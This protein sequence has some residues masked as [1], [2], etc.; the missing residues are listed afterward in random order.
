MCSVC[1]HLLQCGCNTAVYS[2]I[3]CSMLQGHSTCISGCSRLTLWLVI[4]VHM[5]GSDVGRE[6]SFGDPTPQ[7]HVK[8]E[9]GG[10][11]E[12]VQSLG[13]WIPQERK[14][15][16]KLSGQ[17][18]STLFLSLFNTNHRISSMSSDKS[19]RALSSFALCLLALMM[20]N[21]SVFCTTLADWL[22]CGGC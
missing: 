6:L 22:H 4:D 10:G 9:N 3:S 12:H 19:E 20:C 15:S 17:L 13:T 7:V 18:H 8:K 11:V 14:P 21:A 2:M 1:F 16:M 5:Q